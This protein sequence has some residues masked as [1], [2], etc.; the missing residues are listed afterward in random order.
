LTEDIHLYPSYSTQLAKL[1]SEIALIDKAKSKVKPSKRFKK[2]Q[3]E[4]IEFIQGGDDVTI[5]FTVND[6][7][8]IL[9]KGDDHKGFIHL[10]RKHFNPNDLETMDILNIPLIF[11]NAVL[12]QE[13]DKV[14]TRYISLKD[15][16][17]HYLITNETS[18]DKL[19][20][21]AY[22]KS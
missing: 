17:K 20:V 13:Q 11:K 12:A 3:K 10:L 8:V 18:D 6:K 15:M 21:S 5:E 9:K 2:H 14:L 22:R 16:K 19:V 1:K 7:I 4:M